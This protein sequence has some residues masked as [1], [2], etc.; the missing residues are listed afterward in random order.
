[1][2]TGI[3]GVGTREAGITGGFPK[4]FITIFESIEKFY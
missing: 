3:T 2:K 4:I 1:M